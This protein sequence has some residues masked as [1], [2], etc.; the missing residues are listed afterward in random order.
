MKYSFNHYGN[1]PRELT[2]AFDDRYTVQRTLCMKYMEKMF[3]PEYISKFIVET[4]RVPITLYWPELCKV[5]WEK[6]DDSSY[7]SNVKVARIKDETK[8]MI[9]TD[10][11]EKWYLENG[12]VKEVI[13]A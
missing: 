12:K 11:R 10:T 3:S 4:R 8:M 5:E 2:E 13:K 7:I 6:I 1:V 9:G